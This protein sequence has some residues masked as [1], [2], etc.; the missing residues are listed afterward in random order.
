MAPTHDRESFSLLSRLYFQFV[1]E[2]KSPD[3]VRRAIASE[4]DFTRQ[5]EEKN[6]T[7]AKGTKS[8]EW[9]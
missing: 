6:L 4:K 5:R 8:D 7:V 3:M 9:V 2:K 1:C